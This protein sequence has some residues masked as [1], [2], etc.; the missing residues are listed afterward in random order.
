MLVKQM[1]SAKHPL[2]CVSVPK[3]LAKKVND[4]TLEEI[5]QLAEDMIAPCFYMNLDE[6]TFNQMEA[7]I[8]GVH[9]KAYMTNVLVTR[10][11]TDEQR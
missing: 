2:L 3:F 4:M 10:L 6:T 7:K 1:A 11:Q 9:R 8:P 5:D